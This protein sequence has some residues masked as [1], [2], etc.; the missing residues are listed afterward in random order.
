MANEDMVFKRDVQSP[1]Y[2]NL[3]CNLRGIATL[4]Q[5]NL[6]RRPD[7][8]CPTDGNRGVQTSGNVVDTLP[9]ARA[10]T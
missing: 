7:D 2:H 1:C 8:H 4:V 6:R 9:R 3:V 5:A 10:T